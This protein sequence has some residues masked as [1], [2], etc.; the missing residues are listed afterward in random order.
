MAQLLSF[1]QKEA[2]LTTDTIKHRRDIYGKN[3]L[4]S[5]KIYY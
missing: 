2:K 1:F 3:I 4:K 5:S